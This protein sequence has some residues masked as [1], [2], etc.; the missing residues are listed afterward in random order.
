M[1]YMNIK[2]IIALVL[3]LTVVGVAGFGRT[4][5]SSSNEERAIARKTSE[6]LRYELIAVLL[7]WWLPSLS[8]WPVTTMGNFDEESKL[9]S[10]PTTH[11]VLTKTGNNRF[12]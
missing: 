9:S 2:R 3:L 11:L 10:L 5:N 4:G 8:D 12:D 1:R 7:H 6:H